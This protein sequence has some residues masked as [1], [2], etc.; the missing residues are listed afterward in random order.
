VSW[1]DGH[2]L[3]EVPL[4]VTLVGKTQVAGGVD[5]AATAL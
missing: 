4:K 3:F 1:G 5:E 2:A